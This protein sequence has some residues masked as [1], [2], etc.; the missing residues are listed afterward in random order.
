[1]QEKFQDEKAERD[2][3]K[4]KRAMVNTKYFEIIS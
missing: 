2:G 3:L 1:M 4:A